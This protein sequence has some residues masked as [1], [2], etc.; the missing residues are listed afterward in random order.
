MKFDIEVRNRM[1]VNT[2]PQ[3]RCYN[4]CHYKSDYMWTEWE[5]LESNIQPE[6]A[7]KRLLFWKG[8]ND[9][10]VAERGEPARREFRIREENEDETDSY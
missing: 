2:D 8:L 1:L 7:E 10:A 5:V 6:K 3:R 9:Y 4:G